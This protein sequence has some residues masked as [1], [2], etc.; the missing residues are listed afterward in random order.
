LGFGVL[1]LARRA[2]I[3]EGPRRIGH[4]QIE[5]PGWADG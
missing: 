4:D 2:E 3:V 1:G 5:A